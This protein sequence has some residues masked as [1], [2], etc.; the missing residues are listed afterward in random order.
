MNY[1]VFS[2]SSVRMALPVFWKITRSVQKHLAV[3]T[4]P[5]VFVE[6]LAKV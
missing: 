6:L 2:S 1:M 5:V 4:K 3:R